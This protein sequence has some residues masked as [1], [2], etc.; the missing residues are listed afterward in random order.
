MRGARC[1]PAGPGWRGQAK[2]ARP[3]FRKAGRRSMCGR[4]IG[5]GRR[6]PLRGRGVI[7]P[8]CA[9]NQEGKGNSIRLT[10]LR[11]IFHRK[12]TLLECVRVRDLIAGG[13][14]ALL[15]QQTGSVAFIGFFTQ[16]CS[17]WP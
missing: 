14:R 16:A 11:V 13:P 4:F 1:N 2:G 6:G 9:S 8:A 17:S 5:T 3:V 12:L 10:V 7:V 15:Q